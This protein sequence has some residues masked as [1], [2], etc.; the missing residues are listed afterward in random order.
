MEANFSQGIH[1]RPQVP[2]Q[3]NVLLLPNLDAAAV[4]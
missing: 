1:P 2:L 3:L 4:T